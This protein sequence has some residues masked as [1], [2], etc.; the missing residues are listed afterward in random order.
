VKEKFARLNSLGKLPNR[1]DEGP[2]GANVQMQEGAGHTDQADAE[3]YRPT[4]Q[5]YRHFV[6]VWN[7]DTW[8]EART[9]TSPVVGVTSL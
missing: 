4:V 3:T 6:Q 2:N 1:P 8:P 9:G 5:S 7:R